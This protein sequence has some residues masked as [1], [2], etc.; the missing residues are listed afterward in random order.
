[1]RIAEVAEFYSPTGGGV[2]S[3]IDRKFEAA[4]AAGHE[5]FVLAPGRED[6]FEPRA[7][8]GVVWIG[9]PALPMDANY[10]MFWRAGPV[11][12]KLDA[13]QPDVVEA[14]SPWRGAWIAAIWPG[15]A[16]RALF[17]HADP[18][19]SYP[20][21]WLAPLA[22]PARIDRLF[23]A[24]WTYLRRLAARFDRVV[25][26]G[27]WLAH[28]LEAQGIDAVT[29]VPLGID[30]S[31]FSPNLRDQELRAQLLAAC[32]TPEYGK[33]LIGVGR[34]HPEKRWPM[35]IAAATQAARHLPI[36]LVLIG[37]GLD[38]ARVQR[39]AAA[40]PNIHLAP[41]TRDRRQLATLLASADALIHGCESETFGLI[42]AEAMASALPLVIPD[43][44]GCSHFADPA[45]SETYAAGDAAAASAAIRHL[46]ARSPG[47]LRAAALRAAPGVR[48]D[49]R[50]FTDLFASYERLLTRR[51]AARTSIA[52]A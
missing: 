36:G 48:S 24:Y 38:R 20:H 13:L 29:S 17:I 15:Q 44:G 8:G 33:L 1:M 47:G 45:A 37:D 41:A 39:A 16:P 9:A 23:A 35:V 10:H 3:Y 21:R 22:S 12:R 52:A 14:S 31:V 4:A 50:H 19:A 6:R 49:I 11:H 25:V 18:V 28:R 2:R 42:P 26:G 7:S 51:P 5:L 46:F 34:F 27:D 32:A 43:R 40:H 30:R